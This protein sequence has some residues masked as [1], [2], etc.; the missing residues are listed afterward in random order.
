M[1]KE[2]ASTDGW[3]D[4]YNVRYLHTH[5]MEYY[6]AFKKGGGPAICDSMDECG[7]HY[8]KQNKPDGG[9][10]IPYGVSLMCGIWKTTKN[11]EVRETVERWLPGTGFGG[12]KEWEKVGKRIQTFSYKMTKIFF[13]FWLSH[14]GWGLLFPQLETE[15]G[16]R[17]WKCWTLIAGLPGRSQM[18]A[19]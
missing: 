2:P 10:Q 9:R 19:F 3:M 17:Q 13:F 15:P 8:A 6:S 11:V 5:T 7:G 4:T 12:G 18:T 14:G 16:T 1:C